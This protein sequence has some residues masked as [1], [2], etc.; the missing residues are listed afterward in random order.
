[1]IVGAANHNNSYMKVAGGVGAVNGGMGAV[2]PNNS[3]MKHNSKVPHNLADSTRF[4][5]VS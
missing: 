2:S 5:S 3:Y 1:M 4:L